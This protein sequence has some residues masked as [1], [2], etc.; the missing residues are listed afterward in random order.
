MY[1]KGDRQASFHEKI[2]SEAVPTHASA[3]T[4]ATRGI[5]PTPYE[6][7]HPTQHSIIKPAHELIKRA[8]NPTGQYVV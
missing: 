1:I 5:G 8:W 7:G 4:E 3:G 2:K 6:L